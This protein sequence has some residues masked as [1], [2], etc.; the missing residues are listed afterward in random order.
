M[1]VEVS[2]LIYLTWK[3][4]KTRTEIFICK[5]V[6]I[7][8]SCHLD[9]LVEVTEWQSS[10][11]LKNARRNFIH[12]LKQTAH[13]QYLYL[14]PEKAKNIFKCLMTVSFSD[15]QIQRKRTNTHYTLTTPSSPPS[16][17]L[18]HPEH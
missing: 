9:K 5:R 4:Y 16:P 11:V 2:G 10:R 1:G 17:P 18:H 15:Q 6:K 8:D 13:I 14:L 3:L 12:L 7:Y